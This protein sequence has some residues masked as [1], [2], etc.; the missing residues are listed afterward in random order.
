MRGHRKLHLDEEVENETCGTVSAYQSHHACHTGGSCSLI[1]LLYD[2]RGDHCL[3]QINEK[4]QSIEDIDVR[5]MFGY[6]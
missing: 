3:R 6:I 5:Y 1:F 2:L 4:Q